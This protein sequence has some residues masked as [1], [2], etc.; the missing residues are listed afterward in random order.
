[1]SSSHLVLVVLFAQSLASMFSPDVN[2]APA[3]QSRT[4]GAA[5][6]ENYL[7]FDRNIYPGDAALPILRKSFA[8]A[9]FWISAPPGETSNTW[10]G[11]R[12]LLREQ[13]FGFVVLYR[14]R[15]ERE[16]KVAADAA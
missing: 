16:L 9:S 4:A 6:N 5:Q 10:I 8:F 2:G 3:P 1:M 7:G 14:G 12:A 11:N 15:E 13:G